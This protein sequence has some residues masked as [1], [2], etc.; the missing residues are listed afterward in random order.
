MVH[1][2]HQ[3]RLGK[4]EGRVC[5]ATCRGNQLPPAPLDSR[6]R[7]ARLLELKFD[8]AQRLIAE[9]AFAAA[10][11]K[12]LDYVFS[13]VGEQRL[14][15]F[16]REGVVQQHIRAALPWAERPDTARC[17]LVPLIPTADEG[18]E[19]GEEDAHR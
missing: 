19:E 7:D 13:N 3:A 9:R 6:L 4:E 8:V 5:D 14:I 11:L 10:P 1:W 15:H 16:A 2:L 18:G 17:Q 12:A